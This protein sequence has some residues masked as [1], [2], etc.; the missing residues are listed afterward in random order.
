MGKEY[1]VNGAKLICINGEGTSELKVTKDHGYKQK[2]KAKANCTDCVPGENIPY[3]KACRMNPGTHLCENYMRISHEW[4]S[5]TGISA[6]MEKIDGKEALTMDSVLICDRGGLILPVTSGQKDMRGKDRAGFAKR[7]GKALRWLNGEKP[8]FHVCKIDPVNMNTGNFTYEKEDLVIP[9]ITTLSFRIFYNSMDRGSGSLGRGWRH[10]HEMRLSREKDMVYICRG[11][12]KEIPFRP[13]VSGMYAPVMG[14]RGLL[15]EDREGFRYVDGSGDEYA[16]DRE[17]ILLRRKDRTG[18]EDTY[19]HNGKG[20]LTCVK[21]ANGGELHYTYNKEDNLIR[22]RDHAGREVQLWYRYGKLWKFINASGHAYLYEYNAAGWLERIQTPRGITGL[23]NE[24]DAEGRV[25]KQTMPDGSVAEIR[26]DD[27]GMRTYLQETDGSMTCY[28]SDEKCRNI[29]TIYEDGEER[30]EY[31]D[32][33]LRTLYVDKNGNQTRYSYDDKGNL[34]GITNALGEKSAFTYDK[35]GRLLTASAGGSVLVRNSYDG[36]G[37]LTETGDGLGRTRKTAYDGKGL[38]EQLT[39]PDGSC[40][41]IRRD[42][43]GNVASVT[44]PYG[45]ETSYVYD[46]LNRVVSSTDAEGNTTGYRYDEGSRLTSV[47]NPEGSTRTYAY[48]ESGKPVRME[49]Y[50]GNALTIAYDVMGKPEELTDKEGRKTR[51]TYDERGN[52]AEELSPSGAVTGYTYDKNNR[53]S[54]VEVRKEKDGDT[55]SAVDYVY[56]PAGN[57]LEMQA[58]DG[59]EVLSTVSYAYDALNRVTKITDPAGGETL[60]TYDGSGRVSSITDPAGNRR[61]FAYNAAGELT[62][63]TD[64]RGNATRYEYNALGQVA[65][66]TDAAG[67]KTSHF[68]LPGGRLERTVYPDGRQISYAY[69]RLGRITSRTDGQGY[70]LDYAYD[71]M[72]RVLS[73]TS[74]AGQK[75]SYTYDVLGN[76]TSMTDANGNT[77]TYEYTLGGKLKA[78]TDALGNR[79]EYAYDNADRLI[80]ILQKGNAGEADRETFYERDPLGQVACIRDALGN[81]EFYEYDALGRTVL[82]TDRDGYRTAYSHTGDGKVSRILYGDGTSVEMEYTALRQLACVKDWLGETRIERDMAG[83]PVRITDHNGKT[84]SYEWGSMGERKGITYPDGKKALYHYDGLLRLDRMQVERMDRLSGRGGSEEICYQYDGAGRLAEKR[85]PEGMRTLWRYDGK[86]QL[87]E[88][89]HED[90]KGIL[91]RYRYE[92]DLMGNKTAVTKER[93]GLRAESGRYEY[94]YDALSRLVSVGRDGNAL[95]AYAY[96]AFGNRSCM[97]DHGKGTRSSYAYDALNRLTAVEVCPL[98]ALTPGDGMRTDYFYDNRGNMIRQEQGGALI[99]GYMYGAMNRLM[100]AWDGTG[101]EAFYRYNGLGQRTRRTTDGQDEEYLL[102]LTKPYHNLLGISRE[103]KEQSFYFDWNVAAMEEKRKGETG[104]G[105]TAYPGMHYYMQDELGSPVRVSGFGAGAMSGRSSYLS[106]GYDEFGNDLGKE[107]E[108]A[109]IPNPYDGQGEEQPFGYTGYRYDDVGGD[110]FAQAR[111]YLTENGRFAAEDVIKGNGA[112]TKMINAYSYC[113]SNPLLWGDLNGLWPAWLEGIYAHLQFEMEF[114]IL[115][116]QS[117]GTMATENV[118]GGT[119]VYI[120]G[121]GATGGRGFADVVLYHDNTVEIYEI[122]PISYYRNE[123]KKEAGEAQLMRYIEAS[124][125]ETARRGEEEN[126]IQILYWE[127]QFL[128]DGSQTIEFMMYEDSPGMIYYELSGGNKEKQ[129][130]YSKVRL[131]QMELD[132]D[133]EKTMIGWMIGAAAGVGGFSISKLLE[134][135]GMKISNSFGPFVIYDEDMLEIILDMFGLNHGGGSYLA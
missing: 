132:E 23:V 60:Y 100:K 16:F 122:K 103:G 27:R 72:G 31:N 43:R 41:R 29:R 22:V 18:N 93:R 85:L 114:L 73:I 128:F 7:Y 95:R 91:D 104:N 70:R 111:E 108:E 75:K 50:D 53:L 1:L 71:S 88:L 54:R 120:P 46:E 44:D 19:T 124:G 66:I 65:S 40:I 8:Q 68:Y 21:G 82:K 15:S 77:T 57:L 3:F 59:E 49:D 36:M 79:A 97:E 99:H 61:T 47:T 89:V 69:D 134:G 107:L 58:G 42:G 125:A 32:R 67:R 26:Y 62:Q 48:N 12:G 113:W 92:Y 30:F 37:R 90:D 74:S 17:G 9:G 10:N 34:T 38:P 20:Q 81:E 56:D 119:N 121:G 106:Y 28:E 55:A 4:E 84:V 116:E 25:L 127:Q 96:D 39:L 109:G 45:G 11:D 35:E 63:E 83:S 94:G 126:V 76:V 117:V 105:R 129:E 24:Y 102:D 133:I 51:R 112:I 118:Y 115:Y 78:V 6:Q 130:A 80:H 101:Q 33:N 87:T 64:I 13:L 131:P 52:L 5:M 123:R 2:G 86:G 110:Y 135:A 98:D 14:D